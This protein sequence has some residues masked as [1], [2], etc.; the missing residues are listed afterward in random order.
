MNL[1]SM[2]SLGLDLGVFEDLTHE[3]VDQLFMDTQ[4]AHLQRNHNNQKLVAEDRDGL[5]A[6]FI[7][8]KLANIR[9]PKFVYPPKKIEDKKDE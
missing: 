7:R 2:M 6:D 3:S 1:L 4:P 9:R 5:R 8:A